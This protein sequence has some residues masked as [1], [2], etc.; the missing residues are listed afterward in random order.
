MV[1]LTDRVP[2]LRVVVDH[3][4]QCTP[5][6]DAA[7]RRVYDANLREL[8]K[9][10]QVYVKLS[11]I[12]RRV[13]GMV[14]EDPAYYRSRLNEL[15]GIFGEDRVMYGSDWPNSDMWAPYSK[16][17]ELVRDF[18]ARKPRA[19]QETYFWKNA[20]AGYRW[21]KRDPAQPEPG[22]PV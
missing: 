14:M 5:P 9:R 1:R 7:G 8:G 20:A 4:P 2:Q 19:A 18:F 10:K 3:L 12:F 21:V 17:L 16:V 15:Y 6:G 13:D 22:N 11:Q